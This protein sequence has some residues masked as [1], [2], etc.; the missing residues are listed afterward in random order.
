MGGPWGKLPT[1]R[2]S[3]RPDPAHLPQVHRLRGDAEGAADD[4]SAVEDDITTLGAVTGTAAKAKELVD[5]M[6]K[7][8]TAVRRQSVDVPRASGPRTSSSTTTPAPSSPA[9]SATGQIANAIITLA[10][11]PRNL[12]ADCDNDFQR[13][14]W[15][16]VIS[17]TRLDPAR[18]PHQGSTTATPAFDEAEKWLK[19]NPAT[20]AS[21][22]SRKD[23]SCGSARSRPPRRCDRRRHRPA[24][25][26]ALYPA[27][28]SARCPSC[29]YAAPARRLIP[30]PAPRKTRHP[31]P[32]RPVGVL[33][34]VLAVRCSSRSP[35]PSR[36]A[37]PPSP[38]PMSGR[39]WP[40]AG[41]GG[42]PARYGTI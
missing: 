23:T 15:E 6:R 18:R 25:A 36:S 33:A 2:S 12:F 5:G 4:L 38:H 37:R 8:S 7:R 3:R 16:D 29:Q 39:W 10:G 9:S 24:I 13:V 42:A 31:G 14:G 28:W 20:K 19:D 35:P 21:R 17:A 26:K 34:T 11:A 30:V 27:R 40:A 32:G 41:G 22:R 1:R